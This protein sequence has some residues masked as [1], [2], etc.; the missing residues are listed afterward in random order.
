MKISQDFIELMNKLQDLFQARDNSYTL[1][2]VIGEIECALLRFIHKVNR[3]MTM[4]EI[5]LMYRISSS[6]VTRILNKLEKMG[7]VERYHSTDDRRNW[8]ARITSEGKEMAENTKY[9]LDQFQ[10]EVLRRLPSEDIDL[11]YNKISQFVKV[12]EEV[13]EESEESCSS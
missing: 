2:V 8:Y 9:K 13:I 1:C 7:F 11:I 4:K 3:P 10:K 6:K 5:A 12:Y